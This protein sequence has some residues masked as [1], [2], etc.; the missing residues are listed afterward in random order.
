MVENG[1]DAHGNAAMAS[2]QFARPYDLIECAFCPAVKCLRPSD[3]C[4]DS[5]PVAFAGPKTL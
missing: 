2:K 4:V 3:F 5:V 1:F